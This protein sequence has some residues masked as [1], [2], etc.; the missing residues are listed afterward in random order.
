MYQLQ[1]DTKHDINIYKLIGIDDDLDPMSFGLHHVVRLS[2]R[3][4]CPQN[5][6]SAAPEH[7]RFK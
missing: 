7:Q 5:P 3:T 6:P 1:F 4:T 2:S